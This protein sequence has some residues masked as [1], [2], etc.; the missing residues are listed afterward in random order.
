M[1]GEEQRNYTKLTMRQ[2][3]SLGNEMLKLYDREPGGS[4]TH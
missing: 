3:V 2:K 1:N 4:G